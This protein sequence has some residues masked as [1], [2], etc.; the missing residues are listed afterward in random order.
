MLNHLTRLIELA[1]AEILL[2]NRQINTLDARDR[3]MAMGF[4]NNALDRNKTVRE[5]G[6]PATDA[7]DAEAVDRRAGEA[8]GQCA[9]HR[10]PAGSP[11]RQLSGE[12]RQEENPDWIQGRLITVEP[13]GAN[14]CVHLMVGNYVV[15]SA[16]PDFRAGPDAPIWIRLE[17]G[18]V[19]LFDAQTELLMRDSAEPVTM[20]L[21]PQA[22]QV[23]AV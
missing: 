5:P 10:A 17:P 22:V 4:Q 8:D 14:T 12:Q 9:E 11:P 7:H 19:H 15:A 3:G 6:H 23:A 21:S 16:E 18:H 13:T 2:G 20:R 1:C